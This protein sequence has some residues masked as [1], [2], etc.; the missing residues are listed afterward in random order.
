MKRKSWH[1]IVVTG[2]SGGLG[3]AVV[4][5]LAD[6]G[7][8]FLIFGRDTKRLSQARQVAE[9]RGASVV[10]VAA[11]VIARKMIETSLT[12][13]DRSCPIDLVIHLA[14]TKVGN[15]LGI[16]SSNSFDRVMETNLAF[17][18]FVD[19]IVIPGM[20]SR[21]RG[22]IVLASSIAA[23]A[24]QPDLISYSASKAG[25]GAYGIAMR[26][27]L[28][29][30]GVDVSVVIAGYI[31][32]PMTDIHL[33]PT[34]GKISPRRAAGLIARGIRREKAVIRFPFWLW[35][36]A[37]LLGWLPSTLGDRIAGRM[38][39]EILDEDA[40]LQ[41]ANSDAKTSSTRST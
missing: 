11:D 41:A 36:G 12:D 10:E 31:D 40:R 14:G 21:A 7:V 2:A 25:L 34:P 24:P 5:E 13:F 26:R 17:P 3:R 18:A 16:E 6:E 15:R 28:A 35:L 8:S 1:N 30:T 32:T 27:A 29:G 20:Q 22:R 23:I 37:N 4:D 19:Q 9:A 38:R 33:G 39:A